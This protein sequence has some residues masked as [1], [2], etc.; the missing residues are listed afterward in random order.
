M[1]KWWHVTFR[2]KR[3]E[4]VVSVCAETPA[5]AK[6]IAEWSIS[7]PDY[8]SYSIREDKFLNRKKIEND[9]TR[10]GTNPADKYRD[11]QA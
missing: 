8:R 5:E 3:P 10:V 4:K 7:D 11:S 6:Q 1:S 2:Q 9:N